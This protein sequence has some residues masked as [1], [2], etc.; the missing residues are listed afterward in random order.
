MRRQP[1]CF[2]LICCFTAVLLA[3][4][5]KYFLLL[6]CNWY[7]PFAIATKISSKWTYL[8]KQNIDTSVLIFFFTASHLGDRREIFSPSSSSGV[9]IC[10]TAACLL[11][12]DTNG[13]LALLYS[14][15]PLVW[16]LISWLIMP[17]NVLY[18]K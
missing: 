4:I 10:S 12:F 9:F 17:G 15:K 5:L 7:F 16:R 2:D 18:M 1:F 6:K 8:E 11:L 14:W 3:W 13:N